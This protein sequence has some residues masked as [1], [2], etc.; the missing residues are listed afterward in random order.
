MV[1]DVFPEI[2]AV[3]LFVLGL[4]LWLES[5]APLYMEERPDRLRHGARNLAIGLINGAVLTVGFAGLTAAAAQWG[6]LHRIG[7]IHRLG[8]S[9]TATWV[10]GFVAFD[11]WMYVW[12]RANHRLPLLWRFHRVHHA[13]TG[14]DATTAYRFHVGE[15]VISAAL[16]LAVI[17]LLGISL[18][19][20]VVYELILQP[21]VIFHHSN[22]NLPEWADRKIRALMVTPNMHRVHHS[23]IPA[24]TNSNYASIFSFWDRALHTYRK[25]ETAGIR[26]GLKEFREA[27]WATLRGLLS[28]PLA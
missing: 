5:L 2:W 6:D 19:H 11:L 3:H 20:L 16:R 7:L 8:L 26:F 22:I 21:V 15:M 28:M 24:E 23:D 9:G 1:S 13:D 14:I 10:A 18:A 4:C 17:P 25:R 27:R 12:H